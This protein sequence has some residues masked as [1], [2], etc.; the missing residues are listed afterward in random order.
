M[1]V[2]RGL[3]YP[4]Q[5]MLDD[6]QINASSYVVVKVDMVH[7]NSKDLKLEVPPDDTTLTMWGAVTRRVQWG[8]TYIDV[9][10]SAA[11]SASTTL[12]QPN[13]APTSIFPET[14]PSPSP[15]QEESRPSSIREESRPSAIQEHVRHW[16]LPQT[17]STPHPAPDQTWSK[18]MK[19]VRDK[20]QPQ[21]RKMSS[22]TTKDKQ[23]LKESA[24]SKLSPALMQANLKFIIGKPMLIVDA[25]HKV[26]QPCVVLHN[27]YI[28]NYK[29]GQDILVSYKNRTF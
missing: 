18:A 10:P 7:E 6:V 14:R 23:Q 13:T 17:W 9:D 28:N 21:Q 2:G 4:R 20:S 22:K 3:V 26:G 1:E 12:C 24:N 29:S 15:I 11:A 16:S 8:R 27:Y 25:L 19:N 5:T